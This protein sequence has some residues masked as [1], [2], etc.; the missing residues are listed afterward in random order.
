MLKVEFESSPFRV[1]AVA[2][3]AKE[4]ISGLR[5]YFVERLQDGSMDVAMRCCDM[6]RLARVTGEAVA[7]QV[8]NG[9]ASANVDL[10][11]RLM[12]W[13][14]DGCSTNGVQPLQ[15]DTGV[16][17]W[18]FL[19]K[20]KKGPL[21][22]FWASDHRLDLVLR[23]QWTHPDTSDFLGGLGGFFRSAAQSLDMGKCIQDEIAYDSAMTATSYLP[24]SKKAWAFAGSR[25]NSRRPLVCNLAE[26]YPSWLLLCQRHGSSGSWHSHLTF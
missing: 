3:D 22:R 24:G 6:R 9:L 18:A 14:A 15:Q 16:S 12:A 1:V 20:L 17:A 10:G 25:W 4:S 19:K 5:V 26:N 8:R 11:S 2:S 23:A 13:V 21:L 7:N